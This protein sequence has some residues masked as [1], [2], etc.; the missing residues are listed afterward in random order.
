PTS[1]NTG[2]G[3]AFV[4]AARGYKLMLT[5]PASMSLERRKV[6][7]ALGAELV[8]TEPAKGMKG[9]IEKANEIVASDPEQYFLPGQFENP[10]NP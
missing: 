2:I 4:A 8:L 7:K 6:L 10:A 1:D 9:A 5:M 3:L